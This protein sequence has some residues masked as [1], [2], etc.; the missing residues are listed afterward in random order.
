MN[1]F[2]S[3]K[4]NAIFSSDGFVKMDGKVLSSDEINDVLQ[5]FHESDLDKKKNLSFYHVIENKNKE[6]LSSFTS[7]IKRFILPKL[8]SIVLNPSIVFGT[9]IVRFP[10]KKDILQLHQDGSFLDNEHKDVSLTCWIPLVDVDMEN[11]C[12]GFVKKSNSIYNSIRPA[13]FPATY[14]PLKKHAFSILPYAEFVPMKA[15]EMVVFDTK[16]FHGGFPNFSN[17]TRY[18]L[19]IWITTNNASLAF[20]YL[21]PGSTEK[22]LKY[23]IDEAFFTKYDNTLLYDMYCK[24]KEIEDYT[25]VDE[26]V[27]APEDISKFEMIKRIRKSNRFDNSIYE[28]ALKHFPNEMRREVFTKI[29]SYF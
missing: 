4:Y 9:L 20:Y 21:K 18:A 26:L 3:E 14:V 27:Y 1:P 8:Q 23:K 16:T 7:K 22:I 13:P 19:S 6:V 2:L 12:L 15:G 25:A 10:D 29:F 28:F 24:N 11:G 17:Q 5:W